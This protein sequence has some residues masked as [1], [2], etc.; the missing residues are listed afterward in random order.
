MQTCLVARWS[1]LQFTDINNS[2]HPPNKDAL[3]SIMESYRTW[4]VQDATVLSP[5]AEFK[6]IFKEDIWQ[7]E[8]SL[9]TNGGRFGNLR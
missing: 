1:S 5:I 7:G 8:F 4:N 9:R 3:I 6:D 2:K